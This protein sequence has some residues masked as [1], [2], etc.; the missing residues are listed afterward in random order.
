MVKR[1]LKLNIGGTNFNTIKVNVYEKLTVMIK[2]DG[3]KLKA[4]PLRS[5]KKQSC[6]LS[7]LVF[8]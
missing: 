3:E 5:R 1:T 4:F 8:K 7:L 2:L 6:P